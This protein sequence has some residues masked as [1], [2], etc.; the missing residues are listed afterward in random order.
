M[1]AVQL[2]ATER[3]LEFPVAIYINNQA[4]I[5]SGDVFTTKLGHYLID[6]FC[7]ALL[8]LRK[9]TRCAKSDI[10]ICW[11]SGHDGVEG[12]EK[13]DEEAKA[14]PKTPTRP[15]EESVCLDFYEGIHFRSVPQL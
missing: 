2:L 10:S 12:N 7:K 13:A 6:H 15:A 14:V 11:I 9:K 5:K 1:L 4:A 8:R 3:E